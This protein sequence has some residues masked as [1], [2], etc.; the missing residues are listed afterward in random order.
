MS[1]KNTIARLAGWSI[2]IACVVLCLKTTAW[3]I[4]GS[5][6]LYSDAVES[7]INVVTALMA[8]VA[9]RISHRPADKGHPFGHYKAEY[10]SAVVAGVLIV[11]AAILIFSE[12]V[13]ALLD[14]HDLQAPL[15]GM[16]VNAVAAGI[17]G[18]WA[19]LLIS[20]GRKSRSPAL[21]ADGRHILVDVVTSASVIIGLIL[22]LATGWIFLDSLIAMA[23]GVNVL[24]EGW[25][26]TVSSVDGLMDGALD[27]EKTDRI[28]QT[29]LK[30]ASGAIEVHDIKTRGA[31]HV[32]FIEFHLVV[33]GKMSV[34][35]SH[36]ICNRVEDAL[37]A[38]IPGAN[39]TIHVEPD[40][41][42]TRD[43]IAIG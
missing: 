35:D 31:G 41:E 18:L 40:D 11:L 14:P 7:V 37:Q 10:F 34:A 42:S 22:V 30:T 26:V 20:E 38:A 28:R 21:A 17:N 4:T 36:T 32:S 25:R 5:V 16:A 8:W 13:S 6:A 29:I 24:L 1:A 9:I 2:V 27:D 33:D 43:G 23:V 19:W 12:A 15:A 3:W 39:V